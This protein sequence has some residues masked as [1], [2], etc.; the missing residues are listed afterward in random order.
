[1]HHTLYRD[2]VQA[3]RVTSTIQSALARQGVIQGISPNVLASTLCIWTQAAFT[4]RQRATELIEKPC[5]E[6]GIAIQCL[7]E[8]PLFTG[9][10]LIRGAQTDVVI[11]PAEE[12]PL[13]ASGKFPVPLHA[14]RRLQLIRE[15]GVPLDQM[16]TYIAHEVPRNSVSEHGPI[17]LEVIAPPVPKEAAATAEQLGNIAHIATTIVLGKLKKA[18][19][20]GIKGAGIATTGAGIA[21]AALLDPLIFGAYA[22]QHGL[23]TW[24]VLAQWYW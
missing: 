18:F 10:K 7:G 16:R 2:D 17:P 9:S 1:M 5:Q 4:L 22:D 12:D 15:A 23:A 20:A 14:A 6:H 13:L 19:T 3:R 24:F 8:Y 21:T 11:L